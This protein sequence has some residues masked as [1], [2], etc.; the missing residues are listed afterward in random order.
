VKLL[1]RQKVQYSNHSVI[2]II[3]PGEFPSRRLFT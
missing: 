1:F 3:V 2:E